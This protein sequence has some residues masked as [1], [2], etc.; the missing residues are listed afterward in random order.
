[1]KGLITLLSIFAFI[2]F[3]IAPLCAQDY[4]MEDGEIIP[5]PGMEVVKVGNF[6]LLIPKGAEVH[7]K[8]NLLVVESTSEYTARRFL[9]ME[10][11]L[12]QAKTEREEL[13][14]KIEQLKSIIDQM[15]QERLI[16]EEKADKG[17]E[18]GS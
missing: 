12:M 2:F 8:G 13:K 16:T 14:G 7:R 17:K 1:M 4:E 18:G 11:Q 15:R 3:T 5:P 6:N 10:Q 9:D